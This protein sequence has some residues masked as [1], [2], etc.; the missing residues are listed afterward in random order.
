MRKCEFLKSSSPSVSHTFMSD[1]HVCACVYFLHADKRMR[2]LFISISKSKKG[3]TSN[4]KLEWQDSI[5]KHGKRRTQ[6]KKRKNTWNRLKIG[7]WLC[8][9]LRSWKCSRPRMLFS[10]SVARKQKGEKDTHVCFHTNIQIS[11]TK[12]APASMLPFWFVN[13]QSPFT[14]AHTV[15]HRRLSTGSA[16]HVQS[17]TNTFSVIK[18]QK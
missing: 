16:Q 7:V 5:S 10:R 1:A 13:E 9:P 14:R 8:N 12:V 15:R 3:K 17:Q 11:M 4:C 18:Q 2:A 6:E